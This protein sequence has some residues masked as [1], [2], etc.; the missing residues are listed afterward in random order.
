MLRRETIG[1]KTILFRLRIRMLGGEGIV[2]HENRTGSAAS[3]HSGVAIVITGGF[4][5]K[6]AAMKVN[7]R[8][9]H[10]FC[11]RTNTKSGY[12][13]ETDALCAHAFADALRQEAQNSRRQAKRPTAE[14]R[15]KMCINAKTAIDRVPIFHIL[16]QANRLKQR[17]RRPILKR[18]PALPPWRRK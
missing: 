18:R 7:E 16:L 9:K 13:A 2:D 10:T 1:R 3:I 5:S 4:K 14:R 12:A 6:S 8:R 15:P 17:A 11:L